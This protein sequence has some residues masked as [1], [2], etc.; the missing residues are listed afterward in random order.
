MV[1]S[2]ALEMLRHDV[3]HALARALQLLIG[4]ESQIAVRDGALRHDVEL[5]RRRARDG[6]GV[7]V[8]VRT[9][10]DDRGIEGQILLAAELR[11]EGVENT[12]DF[13]DGAVPRLIAEYACGMGL[14]A[15]GDDAPRARAAT[16]DGRVG[17]VA[18]L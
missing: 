14:V 5:A 10:H 16:R 9:A 6:D 4:N 11:A 12:C 18:G 8:D 2:G 1:A 15:G 13:V 17:A 7:V 3:A